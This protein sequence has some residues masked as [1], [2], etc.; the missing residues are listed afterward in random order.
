MQ[1]IQMHRFL[2]NHFHKAFEGLFLDPKILKPYIIHS[3]DTYL[4]VTLL[5]NFC[6]LNQAMT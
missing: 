3:H 5:H 4:R 6:F 2:T 1:A